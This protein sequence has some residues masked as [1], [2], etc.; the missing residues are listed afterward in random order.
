MS[1]ILLVEMSLTQE[2]E[3]PL[4]NNLNEKWAEGTG[5]QKMLSRLGPN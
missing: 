3:S 5:G 2:D 1:R 4:T